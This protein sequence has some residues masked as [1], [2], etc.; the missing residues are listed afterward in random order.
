MHDLLNFTSGL[1]EVPFCL[2]SLSFG[3]TSFDSCFE[4]IAPK[5]ENAAKSGS[6]FYYGPAHLQVAGMMAIKASKKSSWQEVFEVFKNKTALF[7]TSTY[8]L[9][10]QNNPRLAGGMHYSAKEYKE[11][12]DALQSGSI[13]SKEMFSLM[14]QDQTSTAIMVESPAKDGINEDWHYGYGLWIECHSSSFTC[15]NSVSRIS[16]PGAFGAYPFIDFKNNY[17]GILARKGGFGTFDKG[18]DLFIN[19]QSKLVTWA[20]FECKK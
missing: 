7:T 3:T 9:P 16:S 20:N 6:E 14:T 12:L 5:N 11:F 4:E 19:V 1:K 17:H 18:Y 13:V 10:S 15:G 2:G 8:D